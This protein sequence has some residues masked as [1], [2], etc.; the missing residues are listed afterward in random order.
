MIAD[1]RALPWGEIDNQYIRAAR[2]VCAVGSR[3]RGRPA[4][5]ERAPRY[6]YLG[7]GALR[8]TIS[9]TLAALRGIKGFVIPTISF[10]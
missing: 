3:P 9:G 1:A 8:L 2:Q 5:A 6:K 10:F 7:E 4:A